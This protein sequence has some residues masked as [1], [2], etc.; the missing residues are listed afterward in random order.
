MERKESE[1]GIEWGGQTTSVAKKGGGK[2]TKFLHFLLLPFSLCEAAAEASTQVP[3]PFQ[4]YAFMCLLRVCGFLHICRKRTFQVSVNGV[5][6]KRSGFLCSVG[7]CSVWC[8]WKM[9]T[10]QQRTRYFYG[11]MIHN[12]HSPWISF[13]AG[14]KRLKRSPWG[15]C[16]MGEIK[17]SLQSMTKQNLK[18]SL[19]CQKLKFKLWFLDR[20]M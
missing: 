18:P 4:S 16:L 5:N 1:S 9:G 15:I 10:T 8:H 6:W 12:P 19:Y 3:N 14:L 11:C 17:Q 2:K 20:P 13:Y 7:M